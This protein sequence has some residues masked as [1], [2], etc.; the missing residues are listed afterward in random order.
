MLLPGQW[1]RQLADVGRDTPSS[2]WPPLERP[3]PLP[4]SQS[5][6]RPV[7]DGRGEDFLCLP[8]T[9]AGEQHAI[10]LRAVFCPFLDLVV[11]AVVREERIVAD[12]SAAGAFSACAP[13]CDGW[14][15][16]SLYAD[17]AIGR[18]STQRF[19]AGRLQNHRQ[20]RG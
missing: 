1:C 2:F 5:D 7:L 14:Q 13:R 11:V 12:V 9:A 4:D 3:R 20:D 6:P 16:S 15:S 19:A 18:R 10:D 17:V 8:K